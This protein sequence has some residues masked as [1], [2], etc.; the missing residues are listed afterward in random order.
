MFHS[1][2]LSTTRYPHYAGYNQGVHTYR[3]LA[4]KLDITERPLG[5]TY[6]MSKKAFPLHNNQL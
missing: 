3:T 2:I 6:L 1:L 5:I 4:T